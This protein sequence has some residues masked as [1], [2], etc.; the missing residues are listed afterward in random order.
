MKKIILPLIIIGM[1][2]TSCQKDKTDGE[3]V[4]GYKPIY[5]SKQDAY[6]TSV[7]DP[8]DF[9]E[10]GKM[11]LY[12]Q[13][14]YVTDYGNGV[15]II[16]NSD[17]SNPK[18]IKFIKVP[19]VLDVAVKN[20]FLYADNFTDIVCYNISDLS[21]ISFTKRV[22]SVYPYTRFYPEN[23]N[24]YFEC[25]DTTKGYVIGWE[26]ADLVDPKCFR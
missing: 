17:P 26:E 25:V 16:D 11:Y 23:K 21:N 22:K 7:E 4:R 20:G 12:N 14:I 24:G 13:F 18:K 10:P 3:E 6:S 15:H 1:I 5:I 8:Q 2:F 9:V 19:G